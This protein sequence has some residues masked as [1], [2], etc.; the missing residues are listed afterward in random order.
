MKN[1][2]FIVLPLL[3][4]CSFAEDTVANPTLQTKHGQLSLVDPEMTQEELDLTASSY[5]INLKSPALATS[6]SWV[7]PGLGH[8]YLG[9]YKTACSLFGSCSLLASLAAL[10]QK[11][12]F[13]VS[14]LVMF[15]NTYLYG[16]YAAYRDGRMLN[17][18]VG[19]TYQM[20]KDSLSD[21]IK[22]PF[23]WSVIKKTEVWGG[24]VGMLGLSVGVAYFLMPPEAAS[25]S[26]ATMLPIN[27]F[28]VGIGEE[29][30]FRGCVQSACNETLG[31][32]GGIAIS[33]ILFGAAH[34]P[35]GL[36]LGD[37]ERQKRY[38]QVIIP[39]L[40][41]YGTYFGWLTHKNTSLKESVAVH[42][43]YDFALF[44]ASYSVAR[45]AIQQTPSFAFSFN[46]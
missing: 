6:L 39:L 45:S 11:N 14:S 25:V 41:A 16:M 5:T 28:P 19:Y 34:I 36:H 18:D 32:W 35:N 23:Q 44:L 3:T 21:L 38:F 13:G 8:T 9:D 29:A 24:I 46:F 17:H 7:V 33:S 43:W 42:A 12:D 30:F 22:A 15:Q 10:N 37:Q 2:L 1:W 27:A 26:G 4:I 31:P 20:P 40:T